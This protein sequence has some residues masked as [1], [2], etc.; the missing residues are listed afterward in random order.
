M[1]C[2][3]ILTSELC[4]KRSCALVMV[5]LRLVLCDCGL[6]TKYEDKKGFASL[7]KS[8]ETIVTDC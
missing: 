8:M 7:E 6:C 1:F 3:W 2:V 5:I 4:C